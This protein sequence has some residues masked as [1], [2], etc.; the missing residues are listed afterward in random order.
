MFSHDRG[1]LLD[2]VKL[3]LLYESRW[4]RD[5]QL[6]DGRELVDHRRGRGLIDPFSRSLKIRNAKAHYVARW[7]KA[8]QDDSGTLTVF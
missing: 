2:Q 3:L 1:C 6:M 5:V 4:P 8:G 7:A